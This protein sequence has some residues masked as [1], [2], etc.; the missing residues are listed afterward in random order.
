MRILIVGAGAVGGY[1]AARLH[2]HGRDVTILARPRRAEQLR[3]TGLVVF[4]PHGDL[5]VT[6]K[7]LLATELAQHEPFDLILVGTKAYQLADAMNDFAPAVGPATAIMPLLNGM[8]HLE[9]LDAR[10]GSDRVLGG[11]SQ[12]VSDLDAE[13]RVHQF[14]PLHDLVYGERDK[15]TTPRIQAIDAAM[16]GCDFPSTLSPDIMAWMWRKWVLLSSLA[17]T[18]CLLRGSI[19]QIVA[20]PYGPDLIRE[21]ID[22]SAAIAAANNYPQDPKFLDAHKVRLTEPGSNLTASMYRDLSRGGPVEVDQILGDLLAHANGVHAPLLT[23]ACV[24]LKVYENT[25]QK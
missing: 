1:F 22:E 19:G 3:S 13:G 20:V 23:A 4:S 11:S 2:A 16:Q 10:F 5:T 21:I 15:S 18:T 17:G 24:Q 9:T 25:L 12:I 6:P 7:I 14:G 8:K